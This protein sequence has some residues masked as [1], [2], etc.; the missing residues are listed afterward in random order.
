VDGTGSG[1]DADTL[2][3]HDTAYFATSA[4]THIPTVRN[5]AGTTDSP[6][7]ADA[8]NIVT[9]SS[10]SATTITLNSGV[11]SVGQS[12]AFYRLGAGTNTFAAGAAQTVNSP[13]TRL[14][15][16]EQ[17]GTVVATYRAANTWILSG[18]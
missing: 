16:P 1:L 6:T 2:D 14:T 11:C 9:L 5:V 17:Y 12:I 18:T 10:T 7:S 3:G 4:H 13:G 15:I 8:D